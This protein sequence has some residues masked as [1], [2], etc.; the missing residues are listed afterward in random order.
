MQ[1]WSKYRIWA[2]LSRFLQFL[3]H[4]TFRING[5]DSNYETADVRHGYDAAS[6]LLL[7]LKSFL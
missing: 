2:K 1:F 3:T 5:L 4:A 7:R 6:L